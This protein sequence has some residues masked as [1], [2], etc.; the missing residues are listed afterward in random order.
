MPRSLQMRSL[1]LGTSRSFRTSADSNEH[2]ADT[3]H[4]PF[5]RYVLAHEY[6]IAELGRRAF[7]RDYDALAPVEML[8]GNVPTESHR[9]QVVSSITSGCPV[10]N[11]YRCSSL[12]LARVGSPRR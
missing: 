7:N 6:A 3:T 4:A 1:V 8:L 5:F 10:S 2:F 12:I 9:R 11:Q